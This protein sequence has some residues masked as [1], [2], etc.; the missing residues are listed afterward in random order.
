MNPTVLEQYNASLAN[1][2]AI[3]DKV[4]DE[5]WSI[6]L[7]VPDPHN[8]YSFCYVIEGNDSALHLIDPG[9]DTDDNW[10]L[11]VRG[12][13]SFGLELARV[14]SVFVTHLHPDHIGMAD[15]VRSFSGAQIIMLGREQT[16]ALDMATLADQ[17]EAKFEF[18]GVPLSRREEMRNL[19]RLGDR[20]ELT[21]ADLLVAD[22]DRWQIAGRDLEVVWTPGHT[23]GHACLIDRDAEVFFSG[24]HVLPK[25]YPGLG[26]GGRTDSNPITDYFRSLDRVE[27]FDFAEVAPGH[28]YRF[29]GL[30]DRCT[31]LR[32]H[33]LRRSHEAARITADA[34]ESST[35]QVASQLSWTA[36]WPQMT[37]FFL[38]SALSQTEQHV[39]FVASTDF[40][41]RIKRQSD[42]AH[43]PVNP[44]HVP[45]VGTRHRNSGHTH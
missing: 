31:E 38:F 16:A 42:P 12:C 6:P 37:G 19:G 25:M 10:T 41:D 15:R 44:P 20:K 34:P 35:F 40:A 36:G 17:M 24:D 27:E 32:E 33:H 14:K 3:P 11:L 5:I 26:L 21:H 43:N 23:P 8:P 4:A 22:G 18:W 30:V 39:D 7:S 1:A 9:Y 29:V 13:R 2:M 45:D 28:A